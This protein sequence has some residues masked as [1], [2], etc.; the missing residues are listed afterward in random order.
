MEVF[1]GPP[2]PVTLK[3]KLAAFRAAYACHIS[4]IR[5][6]GFPF[7]GR[8]W[9]PVYSR[10]RAFTHAFYWY[11]LVDWARQI[12][13]QASPWLLTHLGYYVNYVSSEGTQFWFYRNTGFLILRAPDPGAA[14]SRT[15]YSD[16]VTKANPR[17]S[18]RSPLGLLWV[19][20]RQARKARERIF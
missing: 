4:N 13:Y 10:W 2:P 7:Y 1:Q 6:R 18:I 19:T 9:H 15:T 14:R 12:G 17:G 5:D 11:V 20:W 3:E 8:S 16:T